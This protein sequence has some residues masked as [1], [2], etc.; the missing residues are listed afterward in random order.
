LKPFIKR[1]LERERYLKA[2]VPHFTLE[3]AT[4]R[5]ANYE[6]LIL[7]KYGDGTGN[8]DAAWENRDIGH[9]RKSRRFPQDSMTPWKKSF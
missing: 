6:Q 5:W 2:N 1:R 7:K 8:L 9:W 4:Q 3:E